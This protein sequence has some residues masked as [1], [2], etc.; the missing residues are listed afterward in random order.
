[1]SSGKK[2]SRND[3]NNA[4]LAAAAV[5]AVTNPAFERRGGYCQRVVRQVVQGAHGN[6][7]D[8]FHKATA[9][10]S[11]KAWIAG[12]YAVSPQNGSVIGDILYKAATR[13]VPEGHVGIR[14]AGNRVAENS[15]T[16]LGRLQGAKGF[17]TLE[18]FGSVKTIVR[19]K[20]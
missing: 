18:E 13:D 17:R 6:R 15:T 2:E 7:Y 9:E 19:L 8:R 1:M 3:P 20:D 4:T 5:S 10:A 12:G 14:V 11:R 16:S